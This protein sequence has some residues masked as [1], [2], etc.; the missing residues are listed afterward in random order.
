MH[1]D[2]KDIHEILIRE[3]EERNLLRRFKHRW[4]D[5]IVDFMLF[6]PYIYV[7]YT[8]HLCYLCRTFMLFVPYII[9]II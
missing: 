8:I 9:L 4:R 3:P 5:V 2:M 1:G 7:I 6:V